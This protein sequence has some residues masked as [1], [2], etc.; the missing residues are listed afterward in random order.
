M[1]SKEPDRTTGAA[2]TAAKPAPRS[3]HIK[4]TKFRVEIR[5]RDNATAHPQEFSFETNADGYFRASS[6][7]TE[8]SMMV[9]PDGTTADLLTK[10]TPLISA[11]GNKITITGY[12]SAGETLTLVIQ[13]NATQAIEVNQTNTLPAGTNTY[14]SPDL[15]NGTYTVTITDA[16]T[17]VQ[18]VKTV[19]VP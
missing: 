15:P 16:A 1:L 19:T 3:G 4:R 6:S 2:P 14:T 18:F 7:S 9:F 17:G 8:L 10:A 13:N 12:A 5:P 11:S